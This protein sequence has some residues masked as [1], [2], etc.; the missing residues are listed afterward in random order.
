MYRSDLSSRDRSSAIAA[1]VAIQAAL[2]IAFLNMPGRMTL[3]ANQPTLQLVDMKVLPPPVPVRPKPEASRAESGAAAPKN[4]KSEATEV[5]A[6]KP[7]VELPVVEKITASATPRQGDDP[8]QGASAVR[9]PGTGAG[10]NGDG[11]GMAE[12]PHLVTPV[13]RGSDFPRQMLDQ[14]PRAATVFLRLR[15]DA[16]GYIAECMLDRGTNV[17]EIDAQVC[18]TAHDRLRFYP[19]LNSSGQAVAGWFGY[20]QPAPR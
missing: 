3:Q 18:N 20:A 4:I 15:V 10:G 1:A 7:V 16:R 6:P 11:S 19:A 12:P 8:T 14:W 5:V 13:L 9:G 2:L 17:P